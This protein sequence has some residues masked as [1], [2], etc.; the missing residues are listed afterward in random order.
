MRTA[1]CGLTA[2]EIFLTTGIRLVVHEELLF[3]MS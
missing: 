3:K 2:E 1:D